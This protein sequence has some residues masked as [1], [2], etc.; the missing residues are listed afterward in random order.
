M[1]VTL[2]ERHTDFA[3]EFRGEGWP[4]G[5]AAVRAMGAGAALDALPQARIA[6]D[7]REVAAIQM[8]RQQPPR[9]LFGHRRRT[10]L[11]FPVVL[12]VLV[13]TGIAARI[14]RSVFRRFAYGTA[15]VRLA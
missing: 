13:R 2:L 1:D 7:L 8:L 6:A 14:A 5:V 12:P 15:D 10:A 3:P 11:L 9:V 4:S